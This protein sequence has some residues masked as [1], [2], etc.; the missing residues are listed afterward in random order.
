MPFQFTCEQCGA[1]FYRHSRPRVAAPHR[2]CSWSCYA[3]RFPVA[4]RFWAKV[5]KTDTCWR[6]RGALVRGYGKFWLDGK[7]RSA[8]R[9]AYELAVGPVPSGLTL[10]H[11]CRER[12]CVN[13]T[14]LEPVPMRTNVLRG[15]SPIAANAVKS[16]CVNGHP[17]DLVNTRFGKTGRR[18]CRACDRE[19]KRPT[20]ATTH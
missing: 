20:H 7:Q 16:Q 12:S 13:P 5:L 1:L 11:L 19:R 2:Y 17:Y 4:D 9:V 8:H 10:D 18:T 14:H 6:W 3:T 15:T